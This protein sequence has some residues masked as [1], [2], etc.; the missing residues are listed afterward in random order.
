VP[1][2]REQLEERVTVALRPDDRFRVRG[3]DE[4]EQAAPDERLGAVPE[5]PS[6]GRA[7]GN[8]VSRRVEYREQ[9]PRVLEQIAE[10]R[11]ELRVVTLGV[12]TPSVL[13][14]QPDVQARCLFAV[15]QAE[16]PAWVC[17][18]P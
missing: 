1:V 18:R 5:D 3:A 11:D 13:G 9:G 6:A 16:Q 12:R 7:Y 8:E 10:R 15:A 2:S 17:D 14:R 4:V